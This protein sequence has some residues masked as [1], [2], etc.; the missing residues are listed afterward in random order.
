MISYH[1][2]QSTQTQTRELYPMVI[3]AQYLQQPL[4]PMLQTL[5]P[6]QNQIDIFKEA[7]EL[8][9]KKVNGSALFIKYATELKSCIDQTVKAMNYE[10]L[11]HSIRIT[12][13]TAQI[14]IIMRLLRKEEDST[15]NEK[16]VME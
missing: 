9:W 13:Q 10:S 12:T 15:P 2:N 16:E 5:L 3:N 1:Y 8:Y 6:I 7:N 14:I 11:R 4:L